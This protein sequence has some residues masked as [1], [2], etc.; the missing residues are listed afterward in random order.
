MLE[1]RGRNVAGA[2]PE[3]GAFP[4]RQL[5]KK[6]PDVYLATSD[7]GTTL[8]GLRANPETKRLRAVRRKRFGILKAGLVEPGPEVGEALVQ[9]A[10]ILH[11]DAFK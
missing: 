3:Q 7:S 6:D 8:A 2:A 5:A 9:V 11:P 10:R 1:A 4:L